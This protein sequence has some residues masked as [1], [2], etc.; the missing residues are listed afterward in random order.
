MTNK[1]IN[2]KLIRITILNYLICDQI[3]DYLLI[4]NNQIN[5]D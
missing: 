4:F 3:L 1:S 2:I 5:A